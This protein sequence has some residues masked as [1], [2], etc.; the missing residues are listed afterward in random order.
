[1]AMTEAEDD[2]EAVGKSWM[3]DE[4]GN[5]DDDGKATERKPPIANATI[6]TMDA[7]TR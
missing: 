2:N 6:R 7:T 4:E 1:M 5:D 3:R